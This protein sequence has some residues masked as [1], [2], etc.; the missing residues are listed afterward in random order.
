MLINAWVAT[1][2]CCSIASVRKSLQASGIERGRKGKHAVPS[3]TC[4]L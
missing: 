2:P 3:I 4:F 1:V